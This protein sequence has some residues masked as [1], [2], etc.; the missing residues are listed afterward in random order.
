MYIS[1]QIYNFCKTIPN[2]T[3]QCVCMTTELPA[4]FNEYK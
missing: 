2:P 3:E 4:L 1:Y